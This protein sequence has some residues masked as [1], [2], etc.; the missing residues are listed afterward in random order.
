MQQHFHL[1]P[2]LSA[3]TRPNRSWPG[4]IADLTR[5]IFSFPLQH[6]QATTQPTNI[7]TPNRVDFTIQQQ[8]APNPSTSTQ[9]SEPI[10]NPLRYRRPNCEQCR[11]DYPSA[12]LFTNSDKSLTNSTVS[13][14]IRVKPENRPQLSFFPLN[15]SLFSFDRMSHVTNTRFHT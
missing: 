15:S 9:K 2:N 1:S 5:H 14:W 3:P 12:F 7:A 13:T 10:S 8:I 4:P 6:K 11:P